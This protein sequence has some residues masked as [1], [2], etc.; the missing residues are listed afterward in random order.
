MSLLG[1]Y[2]DDDLDDESSELVNHTIVDAPLTDFDNQAN[3]AADKG[4]E[5]NTGI[6]SSTQHDSPDNGQHNIQNGTAA[7]DFLQEL[8]EARATQNDASDMNKE[9]LEQHISTNATPNM[10]VNGDVCLGWKMV[11]HEES[12]QYYYWNTLTGETSWNVPDVLA[13]LTS[14]IK[15]NNDAKGTENAVVGIHESNSPPGVNPEVSVDMQPTVGSVLTD[16][17]C[18]TEERPNLSSHMEVSTDDSSAMP[19]D[20]GAVRDVKY[21]D[22]G[23]GPD[24]VC[25]LYQELPSPENLEAAS[26]AG[27]GNHVQ[28]LV[29]P[30]EHESGTDLCSRLLRLGEFL[31]ERF[32]TLKGSK[33]RLIGHDK[34][35]KYTVEVETRLSDINALSTYASSLLPFWLHCEKKFKQL[36]SAVSDEVLQFYESVE[37]NTLEANENNVIRT[38]EANTNSHDAIVAEEVLKEQHG[39]AD[40]SVTV[41]NNLLTS[42]VHVNSPSDSNPEGKCEVHEAAVPD[43]LTPMAMVHSEEDVDMDVEME[44]EDVVPASATTYPALEQHTVWPNHA[45]EHEGDGIPPPPDDDWIPPPPPDDEPFPPPPPDN[46]PAPPPPPEELPETLYSVPLPDPTTEP[47]FSYAAQYNIQYPGSSIEYYGQS[48]VEV[49]ENNYYAPDPNQLSVPLPSYYEALPNVYPATAASVVNIGEHGSYYGLQDEAAPPVPGVTGVQS[50]VLYFAS[51][52]GCLNSDQ[53]GS[54]HI[55]VSTNGADV[56]TVDRE[57][58]KRSVQNSL[59]PVSDQAAATISVTHVSS[60]SSVPAVPVDAAAVV[61]KVHTKVSKNKK[62]ATTVVSTL[63]SNKKVS[64]MVDKWKAAKEELHEEEDEPENAYEML[65]KK[66]QRE[67]EEW[68]AQ[69]IA[70]GEAKD[71]A[72]FQPLGGDWR[73]RVKRKRARLMKKSVEDLSENITNG[74][75]Q[76]DLD[77]LQR[78]LPSG[79]QV[80]WDDASKQVYYGNSVTSETTWIRPS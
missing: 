73:E 2:S 67:I 26:G 9:L 23:Y 68:R 78:D 42:I 21:M 55:T 62:R 33:G 80:Y 27:S 52:Q 53:I 18:K 10:Q 72:N 6:N 79:W 65:E 75:Q 35:S 44:L 8:Q 24:A 38:E 43:E 17:N 28:N 57:P 29:V 19:K 70:S 22:K 30:G 49:Q 5:Q 16:E 39:E 46:E 7:T 60:M 47:S 61:P 66:R 32:D 3:V 41:K 14:E 37:M 64:S 51:S 31:L 34:L 36:E 25:A 4:C 63:K 77:K 71:N 59:A 45:A 15:N 20:S 54:N 74:N 56:S 48:N 58:E 40:D 50:S 13:E 11:L 76:P 12:N 1:Q 69:Q